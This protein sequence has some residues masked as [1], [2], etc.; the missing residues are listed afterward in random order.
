[1]GTLIIIWLLATIMIRISFSESGCLSIIFGGFGFI[2]CLV[3]LG[4]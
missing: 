1:M 2:M 4:T 3:W